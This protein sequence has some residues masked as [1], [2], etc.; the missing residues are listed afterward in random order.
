[1]KSASLFLTLLLSLL[2][3]AA[4]SA[5]AEKDMARFKSPEEAI[6]SAAGLI[7]GGYRRNLEAALRLYRQAVEKNPGDSSARRGA[8]RMLAFISLWETDPARKKELRLEAAKHQNRADWFPPNPAGQGPV[9]KPQNFLEAQARQLWVEKLLKKLPEEKDSAKRRS[10][11]LD[12]KR[13]YQKALDG[14][15]LESGTDNGLSGREDLLMEWTSILLMLLQ[16]ETDPAA[17][18][19]IA[20][21]G[22]EAAAQSLALAETDFN[23]TSNVYL[24]T[25][26]LLLND[27]PALRRTMLNLVGQAFEER[28][29]KTEDP[30]Q[31]S[32]LWRSWGRFLYENAF[33]ASGGPDQGLLEEARQKFEKFMDL[34]ENK[35]RGKLRWAMELGWMFPRMPWNM[36]DRDEFTPELARAEQEALKLSV[37]LME[38]AAAEI[39]ESKL[40]A[41][42]RIWSEKLLILA[43]LEED[44]T[45]FD[46][47]FQAARTL[48]KQSLETAQDAQKTTAIADWGSQLSRLVERLGREKRLHDN[49]R[50][51]TLMYEAAEV[52]SQ[53]WTDLKLPEQ[54]WTFWEERRA[55]Y[56]LSFYERL[57]EVYRATVLGWLEAALGNVKKWNPERFDV[58]FA[59]AWVKAARVAEDLPG[60]TSAGAELPPLVQ[61]LN[62]RLESALEQWAQAL[63]MLSEN[64]LWLKEATI[65]NDYTP[66]LL[67]DLKPQLL[68]L[69]RYRQIPEDSPLRAA[70]YR[71]LQSAELLYR[72]AAMDDLLLGGPK[73][74][75]PFLSGAA[76]LYRRVAFL[77][78]APFTDQA[79]Y[80][81]RALDIYS[82]LE[83][84]ARERLRA[85]GEKA[86]ANTLRD[87]LALVLSE[88]ALLTAESG[89]ITEIDQPMLLNSEAEK[90]WDEAESLAPGSSAYA[91][92]RQ[93][94]GRGNFPACH[95]LLRHSPQEEARGFF[96]RFHQGR[97]DPAFMNVEEANWFKRAWFDYE[98]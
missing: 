44:E 29:K 15:P 42:R 2:F 76:S 31:R 22:L 70:D 13:D 16:S 7:S 43:F 34:E 24:V 39:D 96:P 51:K 85:A 32:D 23:L 94:C 21:E 30:G 4:L 95:P 38:E 28:L 84:E 67:I 17:R 82:R 37:Q 47:Y 58:D 92:A 78:Y 98:P 33:L 48:H 97:L 50:L 12:L 77:G 79:V 10:L 46:R 26:W 57:P 45:D 6:F 20:A 55:H 62:Q 8:G 81:G 27:D 54:E 5:S 80:Y 1:M 19:E 90:L 59:L 18:N 66:H 3:P 64:G 11:R 93:A 83:A 35:S 87:K 72:L 36:E 9:E 86:E 14:S 73:T 65:R 69:S 53:S 75:E 49:Q 88:K 68:S 56:A 91:R 52:F 63:E 25:E 89:W 41:L 71:E 60:E 40:F 61:G 74:A